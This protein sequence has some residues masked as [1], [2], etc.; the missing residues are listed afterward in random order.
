[1]SSNK[2]KRGGSQAPVA[3]PP[4]AGGAVD[5]NVALFAS[6]MR[7]DAKRARD[8]KAAERQ[9]RQ[10]AEAVSNLIAAKD[11]AAAEVKRLR[12]REGVSA[13]QR[14]QADGAYKSALA[15]VV[16]AETGTAPAWAPP[17]PAVEDP[18]E[19]GSEGDA[20]LPVPD[21]DG[22]ASEVQDAVEGPTAEVDPG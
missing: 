3:S 4:A 1:M 8:A 18:A 10:E 15:A 7:D 16:A 6:Y 19:A 17:E 14:A 22:A 9:A 12:G 2:R 21:A 20:E 11:A 13:E 5:P